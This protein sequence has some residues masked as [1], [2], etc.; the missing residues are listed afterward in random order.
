MNIKSLQNKKTLT[1]EDGDKY[2][3]LSSQSI[4]H[5]ID[6]KT[7]AIYYV[8]EETAMRMDLIALTYYGSTEYIDLIC[9]ANA[10]YNP[11]SINVG[12]ILVIP[13]VDNASDVYETPGEPVA[14]DLRSQY[15]D[16]DRLTEKDQNRID[17]LKEKA[18]GKK[19]A[20]K[21]VLPTNYLQPGEK[22]TIIKNGKITFDANFKTIKQ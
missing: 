17:R 7:M 9:K 10:I 12:D 4:K 14:K 2:L 11:F 21:E 18:K 8:T 19:G 16:I 6:L 15:V 22:G 13:K 5:D 1:D 3:D 20:V